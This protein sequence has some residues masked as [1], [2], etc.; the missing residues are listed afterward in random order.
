MD[1]LTTS[2]VYGEGGAVAASHPTPLCIQMPN[3]APK[4]HGPTGL[5]W[6][7]WSGGVRRAVISREPRT[8][9]P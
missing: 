9:H 3:G 7:P 2:V 1:P 5:D 4:A 6:T 8:P